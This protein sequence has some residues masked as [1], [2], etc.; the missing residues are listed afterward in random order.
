[1]PKIREATEQK[2]LTT[3]PT[4]APVL[5]PPPLVGRPSVAEDVWDVEPTVGVDVWTGAWLLCSAVRLGP[6]ETL[7]FV[8]SHS[9]SL[10]LPR[11]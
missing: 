1:M 11:H 10:S 9:G 3:M 2:M 8:L 6:D 7:A 4:I 5:S